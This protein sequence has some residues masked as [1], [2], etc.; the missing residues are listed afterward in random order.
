MTRISIGLVAL[1]GLSL[2]SAS[3]HAQAGDE[4]SAGAEVTIDLDDPLL[5]GGSGD[6]GLADEAKRGGAVTTSKR[7]DD[8]V[9]V[10]RKA[11]LKTG[12][13]ELAP[14]AGMSINDNLIRHYGLGGDITYFLTDVFGVGL[15]GMYMIK[16]QTDLEGLVGLQFNRLATLNRYLW[17]AAL[18]FTYVPIYGK[19]ALFNKYIFHWETYA[20]AGIGVV[21]TEI[22]PRRRGSETFKTEAIAPNFGL[23]YRLFLLDWMTFNITLRDYVFNDKFEPTN[24]TPAQPIDVVE[25]NAVGKFVHN[26]MVYAGVGFYLPPSFNYRTPR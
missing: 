6:E 8:I 5:K 7:Y 24:R 1:A 22:I 21:Q 26:V 25:Q 11:F 12:R 4:A 2:A 3:A 14:L 10:P 19:F 17:Q 23:G 16:E 18:N 9:V 20:S 13:L 15:Q